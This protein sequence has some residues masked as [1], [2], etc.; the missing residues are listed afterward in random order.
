MLR[1]LRISNFALISQ[2]ELTWEQGFT[3]ITGETGSG[4]SILLNALQLILGERADFS[5]IGPLSNKAIVEA[6]FEDGEAHKEFLAAHDLDF[7]PQL[8]IRRE[9]HKDGKS[10]AFINDS[11]VSLSV[12]RSCT[13]NLVQIHSQYNTLELKSPD[14]QLSVVDTLAE[15]N[16]KK[17]SYFKDFKSWQNQ[18]KLLEEKIALRQ[19]QMA[20]ADYNRF[21]LD[22][23]LALELEKNDY[24]SLEKQLHRADQADQLK[25]LFA[26]LSE[27]GASSLVDNLYSLRSKLD[28]LNGD[29]QQLQSFTARLNSIL[30]E[31]KEFSNDASQFLYSLENEQIDIH[32]ITDK[33]DKY[34]RVLAKHRL[35]NQEEL[36]NLQTEL[37]NATDSM[38]ALEDEIQRL[39]NQVQLAEKKLRIIAESLHNERVKATSNIQKNLHALLQ[40]LKLPHTTIE[41][42]FEKTPDLLPSGISKIQFLFSANLGIAPVPIERAASGGELSRFMLALQKLISEKK[43]LPTVLFDEIDTGVSGDVA[44]KMGNL[45]R[46]MGVSRQLIAIS[47]LPQV[48]AQATTHFYV[49]KSVQNERMQTA[50]SVLTETERVQEV[51]RLLSGDKITDAALDTA[52]HLMQA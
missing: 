21:I 39:E 32:T 6:I 20:T 12:L 23:I 25:H 19:Q 18:K 46:K 10:R 24:G 48:V 37:L 33:I 35:S 43:S 31:W 29:D 49:A 42:V 40:D 28:K 52:K 1:I 41:I 15:L 11:P 34:N 7:E 30:L 2:L 22:E 3:V 38:D 17:K 44:Q 50:V 51:A 5:V 8:L 13:S 14:Y 36:Q 26:E 4:K 16:S 9:I 45:L 27:F 47:H